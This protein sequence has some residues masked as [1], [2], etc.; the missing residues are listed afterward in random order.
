M[1]KLYQSTTESL[2][3]LEAGSTC[4][5]PLPCKRRRAMDSDS[6]KK[7]DIE[8]GAVQGNSKSEDA[9]GNKKHQRLDS[10]CKMLA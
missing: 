9:E 10:A 7:N 4:A 6:G 5:P 8:L 2:E 1:S 3:S